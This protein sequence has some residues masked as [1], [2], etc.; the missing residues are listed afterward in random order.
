MLSPQRRGRRA[1][2]GVSIVELMVGVAIGLVVVG[3]AIHLSG[4]NIAASRGMLAEIRV[5]QDLRAVADLVTRDLRRAGYWDNAVLGTLTTA[6][7]TTAQANPYSAVSSL[8]NTVAYSFSRDSVEDNALGSGEQFGF[9]L[10]NGAVE[11]QTAAGSWQAVT[12]NGAVTVT[13]F[14]ITPATTTLPLGHLCQK[15]CL[16]GSAG[17][18]TVTLRRFDI[19]LRGQSVRDSAVVRELRSSVRMRNDRYDGACPA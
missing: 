5:N 3:A 19:V 9:R 14:T 4:R 15:A 18:P 11:M 16:P 13:Q 8:S 2:R 17:C 6:T 7:S 10:M 1:Q 12:D